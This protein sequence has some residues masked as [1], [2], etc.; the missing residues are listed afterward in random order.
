[1]VLTLICLVISGSLAYVDTFTKPKIEADATTRAMREM[2]KIIPEAKDFIELTGIANLPGK[3]SS[4][5]EAKDGSGENS[6]FIFMV[7]SAGYGG[8]INLI[9][10]IDNNGK[11]IR[12]SVLSHTETKGM[13]DAV[14]APPVSGQQTYQ[15]QY[16]GK[17]K[18]LEDIV[19]VSGATVSSTAYK[20]GVEA[21]L[22]AFDIV[23]KGARP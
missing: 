4:V 17:D 16:I 19:A 1:M 13:T 8:D 2:G 23:S 7:A 20:K 15:G 3:V 18:N 6:G 10:G 11:V 14:F 22:Q 5:F 21:A 9:C 12:T